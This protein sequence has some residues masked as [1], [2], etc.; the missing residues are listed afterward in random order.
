MSIPSEILKS[1]F[2]IPK[3]VE[4]NNTEEL[5]GDDTWKVVSQY[6]EDFGLIRGKLN[7]YDYFV[8]HSIPAI[9]SSLPAVIVKCTKPE[10]PHKGEVHKIYF[11]NPKLEKPKINEEDSS[12][13]VNVNKKGDFDSLQFNSCDEARKRNLNYSSMLFVDI[14]QNITFEN[15]KE[16]KNTYYKT[17]LGEIPVMVKSVLCLLNDPSI[18]TLEEMGECPYDLG[19]YYIIGGKEKVIIGQEKMRTNRILIELKTNPVGKKIYIAKIRS[20]PEMSVKPASETTINASITKGQSHENLRVAIPYIKQEIPIGILFKALGVC[21]DGEICSYICPNMQNDLDMMYKIIPSIEESIKTS[22]QMEALD[23][24]GRRGQNVQRDENIRISNAKDILNK[25]FLPHM[26][27]TEESW[28]LKAY[29]LGYMAH[30][31]YRVILGRDECDDRDN[32]KNKANELDGPL[33]STSLYYMLKKIS[34]DIKMNTQKFIDEGRPINVV[35]CIKQR[36]I[37]MRF[38]YML[39]TGNWSVTQNANASK[40]GVSEVLSRLSYAATLSHL[41]RLNTPL[42][43]EGKMTKPRQLSTSQFMQVIKLILYSLFLII[44]NF[45][46]G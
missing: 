12:K 36:I 29:L 34:N 44:F 40:S 6:H 24:I 41:T 30:K 4:K 14:H 15:G 28:N 11:S 25:E 2:E 13:K 21:S 1:H 3:K 33:I 35:S 31:L 45:L 38:R 39:S 8:E 42:G 32:T 26:G 43:K 18:K 20:S 16:L 37:T 9:I 22:T 23:Y 7:S 5:K 10:S 17:P 19:G 27:L 46:L